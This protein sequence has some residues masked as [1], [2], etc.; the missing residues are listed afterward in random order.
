MIKSIDY[1][2]VLVKYSEKI[3]RNLYEKS[4]RHKKGFELINRVLLSM[5]SKTIEYQSD[6]VDYHKFLLECVM[7]KLYF[8]KA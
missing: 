1:I 5:F 4:A 8:L 7:Q 6:L 3:V 2:F